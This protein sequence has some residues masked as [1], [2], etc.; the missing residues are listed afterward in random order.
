M[1]VGV[2]PHVVA[3][4]TGLHR[5]VGRGQVLSSSSSSPACSGEAR[6]SNVGFL[7][8]A[9]VMSLQ[10]VVSRCRSGGRSNATQSAIRHWSTSLHGCHCAVSP[11]LR[12]RRDVRRGA[13]QVDP[14]L[15]ENA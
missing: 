14:P 6:G 7:I 9:A 1:T 15:V 4:E 8:C 13:L 10:P 3:E 12:A 11:N 5:V 2:D